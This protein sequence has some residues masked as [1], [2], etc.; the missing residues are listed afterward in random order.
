M[1]DNM[2]FYI[3]GYEQISENKQQCCKTDI[4]VYGLSYEPTL[5]DLQNKGFIDK[6]LPCYNTLESCQDCGGV[7]IE[8]F[9]VERVLNDS[10]NGLVR[11]VDNFRDR[12]FENWQEMKLDYS[13]EVRN[14]N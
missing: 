10:Q 5:I 4:K 12:N 6:E 2:A 14:L 11:K 8:N 3:V 13:Y 9:V 1:G 7:R